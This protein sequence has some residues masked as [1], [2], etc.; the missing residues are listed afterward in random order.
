ME[1]LIL[2]F[3]FLQKYPKSEPQ[4]YKECIGY[5]PHQYTKKLMIIVYGD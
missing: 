3:F 5:A 1:V 4:A 2:T